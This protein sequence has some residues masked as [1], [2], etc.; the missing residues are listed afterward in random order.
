M[1]PTTA[2]IVAIVVLFV[3]VRP[4]LRQRRYARVLEDAR[5]ALERG[6]VAV[7][8]RSSMEFDRDHHEGAINVPMSGVSKASKTLRD[9]KRPLVV[10]CAS[11]SRSRHVAEALRKAGFERVLDVGTRAN[12]RGLPA[13]RAPRR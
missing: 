7:D 5:A 4:I 13:G 10:Y 6:A 12:M 3:I 11:G 9:K 1:D 8:A 2:V